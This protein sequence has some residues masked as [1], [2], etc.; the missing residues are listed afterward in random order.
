[1]FW[2]YGRLIDMTEQNNDTVTAA[3][4]ALRLKLRRV[5][6]A[7][8]CSEDEADDALQ[9]TFVRAWQ[10]SRGGSERSLLFTTLRNVCLD[11]LRRRRP[12]ADLAEADRQC[13][14]TDPAAAADSRDAVARVRQ[15]VARQLSRRE[16]E[17]FDMYTFSDLDYDEI[18]HRLG[19]TV[20]SARTAMSRARKTIKEYCKDINP[21]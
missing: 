8:L 18:A 17:V 6:S 2:R 4:L 20:E 7:I 21:T 10:S 13:A 3:F 11:A 5:A 14:G 9:E 19:I 16:R 15:V 12:S 1:M